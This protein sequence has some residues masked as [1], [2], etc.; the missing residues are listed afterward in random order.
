MKNTNKYD[1]SDQSHT[2]T[3]FPI[4]HTDDEDRQNLLENTD[5]HSTMDGSIDKDTF[6]ESDPSKSHSF[7]QIEFYQKYFNVN[8]NEVLARILGSMTPTF[9]SGFLHNKIK[10]NPDLYGPFWISTTLIF[11]IAITGNL[12]SFMKN[13]T[14]SN[15]YVWQT[16]FHKVTSSAACILAYWWLVPSVLFIMM[17][18]RENQADYKFLE[19]LC[20]YGYSLSIYVPLSLLWV[21]NVSFLQWTFTCLAIGL[22][23]SVLVLNIWPAFS[24]EANK[25]ISYS[26]MIMVVVLHALLGIGFMLYFFHNP[27]VNSTNI[28]TTTLKSIVNDIPSSNNKVKKDTVAVLT[29]TLTN[30][31]AET[32]KIMTATLKKI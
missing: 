25:K 24:H 14:N 5:D 21:I 32:T 18:W 22:S 16:D 23:G 29:E 17:R 13:F 8:T 31:V 2:F 15:D 28:V 11:T 30:I 4:A 26:I 10:V 20:L 12:V 19:V 6:L 9:S 27:A 3:S 7:Y 1:P